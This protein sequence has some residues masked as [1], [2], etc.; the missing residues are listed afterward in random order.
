M[1]CEYC[2]AALP[3]NANNCPACGAA[4]SHPVD[5]AAP[6][7][8]GSGN[9]SKIAAALLAILLGWW[10]VHNFYLGK[11]KLG[12]IQFLLGTVGCFFFGLGIVISGVWGIIEGIQILT[13]SITTDAAG[14]PLI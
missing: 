13:G 4:V 8:P 14:R 11:T 5:T 12:I 3:A 6:T 2:G 7:P 1:N 9:K 10:G